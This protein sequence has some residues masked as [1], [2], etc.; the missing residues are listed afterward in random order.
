[1]ENKKLV[2]F[3]FDGVLVN[4]IDLAFYIQKKHNPD[5]TKEYFH[6]FNNGN[7]FEN[8][9][10]AIEEG[11]V[12]DIPDWEEHYLKGLLELNSHDVIQKLVLDLAS[13]YNLAIVSSTTSPHISKFLEQEKIRSC[14]SEILGTDV[15]Q[16]KVVKI[17]KLLED[18]KISPED[19][20]FVTDTLGDMREGNECGVKSIG[21]TWGAHDR[22]T[23]E[24]GEPVAIV[25]DVLGLEEAIAMFFGKIPVHI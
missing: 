12:K 10:K 18:Y 15:H 14:F 2:I 6:S 13:Q 17:K 9:N 22:E 16:S 11:K 7:F 23:L 4:T 5:I 21:V 25:D 20:V 19:T 8:Y 24:K 3:D 1:M